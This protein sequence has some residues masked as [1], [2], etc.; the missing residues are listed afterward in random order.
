V[1]AGDETR[2]HWALVRFGVG[3]GQKDLSSA[4]IPKLSDGL[5]G[6]FDRLGDF[7]NRSLPTQLR[8]LNVVRKLWQ[9]G[10]HGQLSLDI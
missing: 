4:W 8:D 1:R 7:I 10:L 3:H 5:K 9:M 6:R 2:T